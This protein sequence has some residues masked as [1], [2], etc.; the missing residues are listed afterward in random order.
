MP[1]HMASSNGNI[2]I[3]NK[4]I[5]FGASKSLINYNSGT[6]LHIAAKKGDT[7]CLSALLDR[8]CDPLIVNIKRQNAFDVAPEKVRAFMI[9]Y[10][11]K[12]QPYRLIGF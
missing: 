10:L 1:L 7:V 8:G 6:A 5:N 11:K 3:I 2:E 12:N 9:D 4:L